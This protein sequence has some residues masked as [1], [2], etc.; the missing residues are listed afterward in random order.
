M[1]LNDHK[2][3]F[4]EIANN[5]KVL[6]IFI[7]YTSTVISG[8]EKSHFSVLKTQP[9]PRPFLIYYIFSKF[10]EETEQI[11]LYLIHKNNTVIEISLF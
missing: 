1:I 11:Y 3:W 2:V 8:S 7:P 6:F 4:I 5:I 9:Q 10:I